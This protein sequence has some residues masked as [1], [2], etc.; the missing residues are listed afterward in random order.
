MGQ[1]LH[2]EKSIGVH[3]PRTQTRSFAWQIGIG[4]LR[5][6][7]TAGLLI[8]VWYVTRLPMFTITEVAVSGGETISHDEVRAFV[9]QELQGTYLLVIPKHFSYLYPHDRIYEVLS[10]NTSMHDIEIQ[11]TS[12]AKLDISFKEYIPYA[13]WCSYTSSTTPCLFMTESGY[14]FSEAPVLQGG[15][16]VRY[17]QEGM[18]EMKIGQVL[19]KEQL[20]PI[21]QLIGR[22]EHELEFRIASVLF[23]TNGDIELRIHGGGMVLVSGKEDVEKTFDNLQTVLKSQEF[24]H[25][26]PGNFQY[27][28]VRFHNKVFVNESSEASASSTDTSGGELPE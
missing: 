10:K 22:I 1:R 8:L 18:D 14:A 3:S 12:R 17:I 4:V 16:L 28:D 25:L 27:V 23:K 24:K 6:L 11:R 7:I 15:V 5:L 19:T 26:K 13:L 2:N 21:E 9:L 20:G